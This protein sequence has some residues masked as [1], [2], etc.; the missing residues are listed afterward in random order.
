VFVVHCFRNQVTTLAGNT[1]V[2]GFADG[3]GTNAR[4]NNPYGVAVDGAGNVYVADVDNHRIRKITPAGAV[5]TLA[6][7]GTSGSLDGTGTAAQ[8]NRPLGVAV[9]GAGNVYVADTSNHRIR[10][11]TPAGAVTTLAGDGTTTPFNHPGGVAVDGTG[12]VYVADSFNNRIRKITPGGA[13]TTFAGSTDFGS[14]NGNGT[15]A[16][17]RSPQGVAVDGAGNVYVADTSNHQIRKIT[18]GGDVSTLAGSTQGFADGNGALA[19]FFGAAGVA[20]DGAGNVYVADAG[21]HRIR[22]ITPAGAVTTVAG[23]TLGFAD[24]NGTNA[25]FRFPYGVA[26]DGAGGNVYVADPGNSQI[27]HIR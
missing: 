23:S 10:K 21:N 19:Q 15:I 26:V 27:R 6:G 8:F 9:D 17:F 2:Q 12:N 25:R 3:S 4:F 1:F 16:R 13:V 18:P 20:V 22:K 24:G 11:I 7:D 5:T 14:T